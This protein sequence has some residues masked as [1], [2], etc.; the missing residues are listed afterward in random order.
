MPLGM[1]RDA[2]AQDNSCLVSVHDS[3]GK[4]VGSNGLCQN[5]SGT[6]CTFNLQA[7][8]NDVVSGCTPDTSKKK[9]IHAKGH[10][11][12]IGK[13]QVTANSG[14]S[15]GNTAAIRVHTQKHGKKTGTCRVSI[16]VK[17]KGGRSD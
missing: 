5:A 4:T 16:A 8:V 3:N 6:S 10:C 7:C 15:C 1:A 9:K 12:A 14:P 17:T 11:G 13:L 2:I